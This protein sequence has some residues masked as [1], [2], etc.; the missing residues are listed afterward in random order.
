VSLLDPPG[1]ISAPRWSAAGDG[2]YFLSESDGYSCIWYLRLDAATR[3]PAAAPV[4]FYHAHG[5]RMIH[6]GPRG[7]RDLSVAAGQVFVNF[8]EVTGNLWMARLDR[9]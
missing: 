4:P 6:L 1:W 3:K 2:V 7:T 8:A 5:S 9:Q